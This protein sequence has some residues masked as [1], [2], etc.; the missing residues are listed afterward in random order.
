MWTDLQK[1]STVGVRNSTHVSYLL[2]VRSVKTGRLRKAQAGPESKGCQRVP[3]A[4][5]W[6][7]G[8]ILGSLLVVFVMAF[9]AVSVVAIGIFAAYAAVIGI[10]QAFNYGSRQPR[11]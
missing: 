2:T 11:P 6:E 8:P 1:C 5:H 7:S 3:A 9:T 10:L 4:I